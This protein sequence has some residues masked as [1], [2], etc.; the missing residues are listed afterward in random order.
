MRELCVLNIISWLRLKHCWKRIDLAM[1]IKP[2]DL[3]NEL[4]NEFF[5]KKV[6]GE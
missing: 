3:V 1:T 2:N 4:I 5:D 6:Y